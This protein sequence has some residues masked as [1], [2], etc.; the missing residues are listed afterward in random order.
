LSGL[1]LLVNETLL[2]AVK[3]DFKRTHSAAQ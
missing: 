1:E 3:E 2:V